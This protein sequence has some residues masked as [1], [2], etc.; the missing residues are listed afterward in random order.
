MLH[1]VWLALENLTGNPSF[2]FPVI[3][4]SVV[5]CPFDAGLSKSVWRSVG[6]ALN[7]KPFLLDAERITQTRETQDVDSGGPD[8][9]A[10]TC[11]SRWPPLERVHMRRC[12]LSA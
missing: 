7:A 12:R 6:D 4:L 2:E 10:S 8:S 3:A 9:S 11:G 1:Q 5:R